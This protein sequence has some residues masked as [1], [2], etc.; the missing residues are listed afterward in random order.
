VS[1]RVEMRVLVR[2][3][4][5]DAG[6]ETVR[7][8][9]VSSPLRA[10]QGGIRV[11]LQRSA[12]GEQGITH[13]LALVSM[14]QPRSTAFCMALPINLAYCTH[15]MGCTN[16]ASESNQLALRLLYMSAP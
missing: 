1:R 7:Q 3:S 14:L 15:T 4:A 10:A 11:R 16:L 2:P 9:A 12:A 6:R 8:A 5:V 13:R